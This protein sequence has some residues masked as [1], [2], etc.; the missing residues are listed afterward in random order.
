MIHPEEVRVARRILAQ[1]EAQ[2]SQT[3]GQAASL[4][5]VGESEEEARQLFGQD[6][7]SVPPPDVLLEAAATHGDA[8]VRNYLAVCMTLGWCV[9]RKEWFS[10]VV[11]AAEEAA[12]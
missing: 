6:D 8:E 9:S 10:R 3:L 4:S 2:V 11:A 1:L 7:G 5:E 12:G